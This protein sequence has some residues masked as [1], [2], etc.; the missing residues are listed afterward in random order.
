[1]TEPSSL[2]PLNTPF[3]CLPVQ[4]D[5][6]FYNQQTL[7]FDITPRK[8]V[9][10]SLEIRDKPMQER[11]TQ[12]QDK[13]RDLVRN[14]IGEQARRVVWE[15]SYETV[16]CRDYLRLDN[17][18]RTISAILP[19]ARL[20]HKGMQI[21]KIFSQTSSSLQPIE[22]E[23]TDTHFFSKSKPITFSVYQEGHKEIYN[24]ENIE[25]LV[26]ILPFA[27]PITPIELKLIVAK[28]MNFVGNN[29]TRI[30]QRDLFS[31]I[32]LSLKGLGYELRIPKTWLILGRDISFGTESLNLLK[33]DRLIKIATK[34]LKNLKPHP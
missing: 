28:I 23:R 24:R 12:T 8:W 16:T 4:S 9:I 26:K 32:A 17:K 34:Q 10:A 11:C 14:L 21:C 31:K 30:E 15:K 22:F 29:T 2:P 25:N 27:N 7:R 20:L 19:F 3:K 6:V 5:Y 33:F 18:V 13:L 1:M